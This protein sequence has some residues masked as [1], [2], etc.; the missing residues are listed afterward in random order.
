[1]SDY[2]DRLRKSV[3]IPEEEPKKRAGPL[4][5]SSQEDRAKAYEEHMRKLQEA[6]SDPRGLE[7]WKGVLR[8]RRN[9]R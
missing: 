8:G 5:P 6:G 7:Q 4:L 1:M 2:L 9:R 3:G